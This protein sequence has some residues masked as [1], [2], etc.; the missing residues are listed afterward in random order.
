MRGVEK[1]LQSLRVRMLRPQFAGLFCGRDEGIEHGAI[2]ALRAT[3]LVDEVGRVI[4]P[5]R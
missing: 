1:R 3:K 2:A 4:E 5:I